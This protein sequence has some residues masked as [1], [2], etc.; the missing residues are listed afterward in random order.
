MQS[1]S[2]ETLGWKKHKLD[3]RLPGEISITSDMQ[4]TSPPPMSSCA[5]VFANLLNTQLGVGVASTF[6]DPTGTPNLVSNFGA[7]AALS[8]NGQTLLIGA[9]GADAGG[10]VGAGQVVFYSYNAVSK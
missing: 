9:P 7:A 1:T 5:P 4:M 2:R 6:T 10:A 3:S 8:S